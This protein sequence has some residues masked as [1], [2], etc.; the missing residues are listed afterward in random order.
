MAFRLPVVGLKFLYKLIFASSEEMPSTYKHKQVAFIYM[1][2]RTT[3]SCDPT[4]CHCCRLSEHVELR[5][6]GPDPHVDYKRPP[7]VRYPPLRQT[8]TITT[9]RHDAGS[10]AVALRS[11]RRCTSTVR[12]DGGLLRGGILRGKWRLSSAAPAETF[13]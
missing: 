9:A 8:A 3:R 1:C 11:D 13:R 7:G 6:V 10:G 12:R 2:F 4:R 5:S